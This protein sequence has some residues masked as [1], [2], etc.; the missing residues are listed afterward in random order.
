[1]YF[2]K[3]NKLVE[4]KHSFACVWFLLIDVHKKT[5]VVEA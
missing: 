1:M 4:N 2:K 5:K 3:K